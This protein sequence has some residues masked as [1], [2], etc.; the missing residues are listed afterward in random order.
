MK[1]KERT[2]E[3]CRNRGEAKKNEGSKEGG[4]T[5]A[6]QKLIEQEKER[7]RLEKIKLRG[8]F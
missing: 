1:K 4:R 7:S 5:K 2:L 3:D 8:T 6:K